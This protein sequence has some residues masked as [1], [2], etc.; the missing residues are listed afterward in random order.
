[1]IDMASNRE[2]QT[3]SFEIPCQ[4]KKKSWQTALVKTWMWILCKST[5]WY[6]LC[7]DKL[8]YYYQNYKYTCILKHQIHWQDC[9]LQIFLRKYLQFTCNFN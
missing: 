1:M 9:I 3:N 4:K 2:M 7:G 8:G 5:S 6:N